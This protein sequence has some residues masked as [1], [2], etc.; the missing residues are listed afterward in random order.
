MILGAASCLLTPVFAQY[1]G[2]LY[3]ISRDSARVREEMESSMERQRMMDKRRRTQETTQKQMGSMQTAPGPVAGSP[4]QDRFVLLQARIRKLEGDRGNAVQQGK[5]AEEI[6]S[7]DATLQRLRGEASTL[8][9]ALG[10]PPE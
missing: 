5:S 8:R 6:A 1:G 2:D 7:I 10:S 9:T 4:L 3:G